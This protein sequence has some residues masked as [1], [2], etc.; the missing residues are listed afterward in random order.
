MFE[1]AN[2]IARWANSLRSDAEWCVSLDAAF[3]AVGFDDS[4]LSKLEITRRNYNRLKAIKDHIWGMVEIEPTDAWLLDSPI[5]QRMRHVR[6]TGFTYLTYPNAHHTRFE[7]SL[8]VYF[9]VKRLLATFRRTRD[10]F[11]I[12]NR[13]FGSQQA[14]FRPADYDRNSRQVR[15]LLHAALLHDAGHAIFSHVS[16][17]LFESHPDELRIGKKLVREFR[18]GFQEKYILVESKIQTGRRKPLAELLTVAIITSRRFENFYKLLPGRP[19]TEPFIDLCDI[20]ALVL[21]DRIESNDFALPEILSGPVDAD[22][23]DY[24]IRDAQA[25]GISIGVDVA[26]VFVRAGTYEGLASS[27]E[28]L[29]LNGYNNHEPIRLFVIEQSGTDAVRELGSAR[30]SLYERVYN[31]QLTRGAQAAFNDMILSATRSRDP[32]VNKFGDYL[33]LW[34]TP[35]DVVL[36][37]L[38]RCAEHKVSVIARSLLIRHLPKRA[39]CFG[40][41]YLHAPE[42]AVEIVNNALQD[43]HELRIQELSG[44]LL[45]QLEGQIG[46][47]LIRKVQQEASKIRDLLSRDPP[48]GVFLPSDELPNICRFLAYPQP[49]DSTPPPALVIRGDRVERFGDRYFSY[50]YAGETSSQI[51]YLLVS[52]EWRE[53][54]LLAF[55]NVLYRNYAEQYQ[56][57]IELSASEA[58]ASIRRPSLK[59]EALFRPIL[60]LDSAA[61]TSK[62]RITNIDAIGSS[63]IQQGYFDALPQLWPERN[64]QDIESVA[65]R[66]SEFSGEQGWKVRPSHVL[67][68]ISQFP[69]RLRLELLNLLMDKE[70]FLFLN[71]SETVDL[72]ISGLAKLNIPRPV[73]LVPLT[74]SSGQYIRT[75]IRSGVGG[76]V[77]V[78]STLAPALE[79]VQAGGGSIVFIDDNIASGTQAARQ[80]DIYMGGAAEK[81]HGNYINENLRDEHKSV[82]RECAVGAVFAVGF[83]DG[84]RKFSEAALR[85]G[86]Q[87]PEENVEW[88]KSLEDASGKD[89]LSGEMRTFLREVGTALLLRKFTREGNENASEIAKRF[90]L[91]YGELEGLLVTP[92]SVPTSTYPAFWCPGFRET[93]PVQDE[94][95]IK[96]P[97]VPLFIRTDMLQ[98]L[99]LG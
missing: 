75:N 12:E 93:S 15:L 91:G 95:S 65:N 19:D 71:R 66:F 64:S 85:H 42:S 35:E 32:G 56:V 63:L 89:I 77:L 31:H 98:H 49:H 2:R 79:S 26:R 62:L 17:R 69:P 5:S 50:L 83:R 10:A 22:K 41:E 16:E 45:S 72:V 57:E 87:L 61:R 24:M 18:E 25:C 47:F 7:H 33:T 4:F 23:I 34:Q 36:S 51:G 96:Q 1:Y 46:Q 78:H 70:R 38:A 82:I 43:S 92:S 9:V 39:A 84:R 8:G 74:P 76:E 88:G 90:A 73:N 13:Q 67:S 40:R 44:K 37:A 53:I 20:S 52:D 28:N 21:G 11:D 94:P 59:L 60:E 97:W 48:V 68:F 99:V 81:P 29:E 55:Q 27:V 86:I 54:A 80:L 3:D 58:E 30:L 14:R 6:Q